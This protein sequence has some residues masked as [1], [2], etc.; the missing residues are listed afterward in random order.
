M[1]VRASG[2]AGLLL[3]RS[4]LLAQTASLHADLAAALG[5]SRELVRRSYELCLWAYPR[6]QPIGGGSSDYDAALISAA[7]TDAPLCAACEKLRLVAGVSHF[8]PSN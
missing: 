8:Y 4:A 7:M 6:I 2:R 1:D 5:R 3:P